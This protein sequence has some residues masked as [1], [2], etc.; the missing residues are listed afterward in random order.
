MYILDFKI[1][2]MIINMLISK[3]WTGIFNFS[4]PVYL[5]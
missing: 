2:F 1:C 5:H 3:Y 4:E